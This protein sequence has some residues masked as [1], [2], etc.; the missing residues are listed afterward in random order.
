MAI[1]ISYRI[2]EA[3]IE[4]V[5]INHWESFKNLIL[6]NFLPHRIFS[7]FPHF[8]HVSVRSYNFTENVF[9]IELSLNFLFLDALMQF[10]FNILIV[11]RWYQI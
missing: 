1:F 11:E 10:Y 9:E 4:L 3:A 7:I 5:I 8:K 2:L 6:Q